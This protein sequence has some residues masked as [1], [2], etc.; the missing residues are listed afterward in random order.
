[1]PWLGAGTVAAAWAT[2]FA[3]HL[4]G[5]NGRPVADGLGWA[6]VALL[7]AVGAFSP[8]PAAPIDE[9]A[10]TGSALAAAALVSATAAALHRSLPVPVRWV[11]I[12]VLAGLPFANSAGPLRI[13]DG[14]AAL[15]LDPGAAT[16]LARGN[17]QGVAA[18]PSPGLALFWRVLP[19]LIVFGAGL[20]WV[21]GP[22]RQGRQP[23]GATRRVWIGAAGLVALAAGIEVALGRTLALSPE[24]A[25]L[26]R[27][28][29]REL[30]VPLHPL[31][32]PALDV[33]LAC[34][35]VARTALCAWLAATLEA[36]APLVQR[37][38]RAIA[39]AVA[40]M[41]ALGVLWSF[42]APGQHGATWHADPAAHAAL[43]AIAGASV[44][45]SGAYGRTS[46]LRDMGAVLAMAA[47]A[48]LVGGSDA[49]WAVAGRLT[50]MP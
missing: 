50:L 17:L 13:A 48:V 4:S 24:G 2:G 25:G 43:A 27:L 30:P 40:A 23:Q 15:A 14:A 6:T 9:I 28:P 42:M 34:F 35:A 39:G 5:A 20:S 8:V 19:L 29:G 46:W 33:S 47:C 7:A 10:V 32:E 41:L 45:L 49:G 36:P 37:P 21:L 31:G 38:G 11:A 16:W 26:V 3:L 12:A 22:R 18:V 44:A 1:M